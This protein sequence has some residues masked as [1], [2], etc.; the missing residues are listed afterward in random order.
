MVLTL[1]GLVSIVGDTASKL[2]DFTA[3]Q[4][5]LAKATATSTAM[6]LYT[7]TNTVAQACPPTNADWAAAENLPP[8][9]N[10]DVCDCMVKS[11]SCA[12]NTGLSGNETATL[13]DTVCGL[14]SKACDGIAK[15]ATTGVYG[16]YSMCTSYQQL[17]F[18]FDQYYQSQ[19][20][21]S[22]AC[23]FGGNAKLQ[24]AATDS[25]C[26]KLLSQ[27]GTAG[28]GT[29]TTAPTGTGS[30]SAGTGTKTNAAGA[31]IIPRF[32][33]GLLHLS[34]YIFVAGMTGMGMIML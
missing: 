25:T 24:T 26:S 6:S 34:A 20:K 23:G 12:A 31:M 11:L 15:N 18:A 16:A 8:I 1:A 13:F 9:A 17:S 27:A 29:V 4:A 22:T 33:V 30:S 5:Q 3:L 2:P 10:S 14:D 21:A 7:V 32:D 28:T 19:G